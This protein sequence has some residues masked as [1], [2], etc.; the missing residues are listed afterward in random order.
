MHITNN[1][2][3]YVK[4]CM[5]QD[6]GN[7]ERHLIPVSIFHRIQLPEVMATLY[8]WPFTGGLSNEAMQCCGLHGVGLEEGA[9]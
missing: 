9:G 3:S 6:E 7:S 8:G 2:A 5:K 4:A 1:I